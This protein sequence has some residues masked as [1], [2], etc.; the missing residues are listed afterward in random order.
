MMSLFELIKAELKAVLTN[1]VIV[2]TIFGGVL[3]YS[4]LY[5]LP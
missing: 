2:L 1:P 4:F 3:F 5:P